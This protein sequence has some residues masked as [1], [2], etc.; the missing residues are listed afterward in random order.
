[1]DG[2][3][4]SGDFCNHEHGSG[5]YTLSEMEKLPNQVLGG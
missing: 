5:E 3:G 2:G 4:D 1:M